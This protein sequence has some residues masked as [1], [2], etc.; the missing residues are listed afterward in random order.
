MCTAFLTGLGNNFTELFL[1]LFLQLLQLPRF[2]RLCQLPQQIPAGNFAISPVGLS[3]IPQAAQAPGKMTAPQGSLG[4]DEGANRG[5]IA[6]NEPPLAN[7]QFHG[8]GL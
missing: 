6:V 2:Q 8:P 1:Q 7:G 3:P 4:L 5:Q